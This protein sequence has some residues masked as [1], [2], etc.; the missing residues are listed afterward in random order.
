MPIQDMTVPFRHRQPLTEAITKDT[1]ARLLMAV[2]IATY[3]KFKGTD[4]WAATEAW[5]KEVMPDVMRVIGAASIDELVAVLGT[6]PV[7]GA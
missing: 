5:A 1:V 7:K 4:G 6:P 2:V 3:P